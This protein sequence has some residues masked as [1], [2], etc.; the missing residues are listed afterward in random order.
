[1]SW[2]AL[3]AQAQSGARLRHSPHHGEV[4]WRA[5]AATGLELARRDSRVDAAICLS[6]AVLHDCRRVSEHRDPHHGPAAA[7]VARSSEALLA[8]TGRRWWPRP[9]FTTTA[10]RPAATS[11]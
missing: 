11:R 2:M 3:L 8:R 1:M 10:E 7:E 9:A 5:V 6:F 4:H